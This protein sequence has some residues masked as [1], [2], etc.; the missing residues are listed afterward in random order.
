MRTP[1]AST[2][3][4]LLLLCGVACDDSAEAR[5]VRRE[6]S[7]AFEATKNWT[8]AQ[9][10][11]FSEEAQKRTG[12]LERRI[13][14]LQ[15]RLQKEGAAASQTAREQLQ[16]AERELAELRQ[17]LSGLG[18]AGREAWGDA[19]RTFAEG[20]EELSGL[21]DRAAGELRDNDGKK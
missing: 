12:E 19:R 18:D 17:R 4:A 6:M 9:W 20:A 15:S 1:I 11:S 3:L 13:G 7:D 14:D 21:L 2:G 10:E 5:E 16:R 8:R